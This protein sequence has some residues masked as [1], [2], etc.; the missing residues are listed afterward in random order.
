MSK[1]S[2]LYFKL[3]GWVLIHTQ[4]LYLW[5][6]DRTGIYAATLAFMVYV[7][8]VTVGLFFMY[9]PKWLGFGLIAISGAFLGTRYLQQDK[10]EH[11]AYNAVSLMIIQMPTR[12]IF[13]MMWMGFVFVYSITLDA[14]AVTLNAIFWWYGYVYVLMI[15]DRDKKPF[16]EEKKQLALQGSS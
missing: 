14:P 7:A 4:M 11:T 15:R 16:F 12:H 13:N 6:L 1:I 2:E 5:L 8:G 10:G 9:T 3:D